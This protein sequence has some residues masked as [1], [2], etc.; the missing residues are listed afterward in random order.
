M[1]NK[2]K[3]CSVQWAAQFFV[4]AELTRKGYIISFTLG[5]TSETDLHVSNIDLSTQ[6]RVDV[7]GHSKKNF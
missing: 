7:K 3:R 2:V 1:A 5:N 4:A 6:F